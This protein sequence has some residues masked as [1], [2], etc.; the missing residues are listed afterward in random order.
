LVLHRLKRRKIDISA[1]SI[2]QID[3]A[4]IRIPP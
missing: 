2:Q 4:A 3:R 1:T